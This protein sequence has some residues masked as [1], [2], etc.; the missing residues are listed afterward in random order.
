MAK[1]EYFP[2]DIKI[3]NLRDDGNHKEAMRLAYEFVKTKQWTFKDF[4]SFMNWWESWCVTG[5]DP[6]E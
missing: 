6:E 4:V 3:V 5:D 1:D 2:G